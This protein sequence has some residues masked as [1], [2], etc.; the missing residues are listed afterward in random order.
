MS[1]KRTDSNAYTIIFAI[2]MVVMVGAI[3]AFISSSLS[4]KIA[5]NQRFEAQQSIL[6]TIGVN[7][8]NNPYSGSGS[9][10][11]IP[12]NEVQ[13]NFDKYITKQIIFQGDKQAED[14]EAYLLDIKA[15]EQKAKDLNY[16]RKLPLLIGN[17]DGKEFYIIPMRG[18]GLWD[19][20]WGYMAINKDFTIEGVFFDHASETPGLGA[21]IKERYFM[22]DFHGEKIVDANH[23][24]QGIA[25]AK[26]NMDP[27]NERKDDH[28]VDAIA[29][30]T[31]T[32]NGVSDM[33][34]ETIDMYAPYLLKL[35]KAN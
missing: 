21:N 5:E 24:F 28:K 19:A 34:N 35:S 23:N 17:K 4:G 31:I 29:G 27:L 9:V 33:I 1:E 20:I 18:K 22:D 16:Q 30:A 2:I 26:G 32:G 7:N 25:V 10:A 6:Y 15:E 3:L 13:K 11:F 14:N 8:N 12:A